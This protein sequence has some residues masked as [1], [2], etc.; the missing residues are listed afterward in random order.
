MAQVQSQPKPQK[1]LD[2]QI[3]VV[4]REILFKQHGTWSGIK[5]V[6]FDEYM[7]TIKDA[8]E[9]QPRS[10][11]EQDP[12]YKQIIPYLVFKHEN[13]Y[14]LMQRAAKAT[15]KRLQNKFTLGI[16]G[17]VREEDMETDSLFD[18]ARREFHEEIN[19]SDEFNFKPLGILNDDSNDVGK[20]HIGFV[21]LIEGSTNNIS[22][23]SELTNGKMLTL[24]EIEPQFAQLESWSQLVFEQLIQNQ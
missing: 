1:S 11:M 20:V 17:H 4:K 23:K 15:E 3:L 9:F 18:W 6:N 24:S 21:F 10:T 22:I 14:F 5:S 13:K 8:R 2:E 16:G 12:T 7:A 19:Y